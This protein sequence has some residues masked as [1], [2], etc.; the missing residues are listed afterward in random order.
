MKLDLVKGSK[1]YNREELYE[2]RATLIK[3]VDP[4]RSKGAEL[5][6]I[7]MKCNCMAMDN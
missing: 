7:L 3:V 2:I 5:Q 1:K 6:E 4:L